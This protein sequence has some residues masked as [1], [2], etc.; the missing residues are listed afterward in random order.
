MTQMR[1]L[2]RNRICVYLR[3]LRIKCRLLFCEDLNLVLPLLPLATALFRGQ[4]DEVAV[5][6][7][8][9]TATFYGIACH[10]KG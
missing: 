8:F 7:F 6:A 5:L 10:E 3:H 9:G 2:C 4:W 1:F